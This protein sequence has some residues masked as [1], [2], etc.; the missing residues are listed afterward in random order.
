MLKEEVE[1]ECFGPCC[2]GASFPPTFGAEAPETSVGRENGRLFTA[3]GPEKLPALLLDPKP[4]FLLNRYIQSQ[5]SHVKKMVPLCC[6][7]KRGALLTVRVIPSRLVLLAW[8]GSL[9][10]GGQGTIGDGPHGHHPHN[11]RP[12]PQDLSQITEPKEGRM[13]MCLS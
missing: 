7:P 9:A 3:V 13:E 5:P 2:V 6:G 10:G 8:T 1:T 4:P 11:S 12:G